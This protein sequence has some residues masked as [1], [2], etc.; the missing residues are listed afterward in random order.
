M[1][2]LVTATDSSVPVQLWSVDGKLIHSLGRSDALTTRAA[3]SAVQRMSPRSRTA[4]YTPLYADSGGVY[5]WLIAPVLTGSTVRGWLATEGHL[6]QSASGER[7][8]NALIGDRTAVYF[9]NDTGGF[10]TTI[11]GRQV[12]RPATAPAMVTAGAPPDTMMYGRPN[13]GTVLAAEAPIAGTPWAVVLEA[14]RAGITASAR[15]FL[16]TFALLGVVLLAL[17]A[18]A[19]WLMSTS[20]TRPITRLTDAATRVAQGDYATRVESDGGDELARLAA[21]FNRMASEIAA[22]HSQMAGQFQQAQRL[23]SELD[24]A[25]VVAVSASRA[26]SNFL[27]TMSHEIRT[28]INAILGYTDILAL[29]ISGPLSDEQLTNLRRIQASTRHLLTLVNEVLDLAKIESGSMRLDKTRS[30][31][32]RMIEAAVTLIDP[33]AQA[34][35]LTLNDGRIGRVRDVRRR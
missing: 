14:D 33:Q 8:L 28:P 31:T 22:S 7:Q 2:R 20:I 12:V 10:W 35:A 27:A 3:L 16:V 5:Y 6:V 19:A 1:S 29:G 4:A 18:T 9:R 24:D 11:G 15:S 13:R 21:A 34:K 32:K 25:R 23:A 26:K 30:S 17:S